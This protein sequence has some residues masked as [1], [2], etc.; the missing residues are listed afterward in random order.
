VVEIIGGSIPLSKLTSLLVMS[1][2]VE[3]TVRR[4]RVGVTVDNPLTN[5]IS[6]SSTNTPLYNTE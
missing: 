2:G 3:L 4:V 1:A 5:I 6:S